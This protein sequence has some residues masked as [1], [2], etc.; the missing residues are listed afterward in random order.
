MTKVHKTYWC[1]SSVGYQDKRT[2]LILR[3][4]T[5]NDKNLLYL[6]IILT[7]HFFEGQGYQGVTQL[8]INQS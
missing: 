2:D 6:P 4:F 1:S 3:T 8:I 7:L 5:F